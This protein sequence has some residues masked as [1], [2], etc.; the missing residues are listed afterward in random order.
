MS[1][2]ALAIDKAPLML[3]KEAEI[4]FLNPDPES[5]F[6]FLFFQ[7]DDPPLPV[8]VGSPPCTMKSLI[9]R[10]KVVLL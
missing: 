10:W 4:S 7:I 8:P 1:A 9:T 3:Y 6:E 5:I 2:P